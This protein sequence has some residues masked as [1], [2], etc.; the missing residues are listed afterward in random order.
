MK[1]SAPSL[2]TGVAAMC[3][4]VIAG[5]AIDASQNRNGAPGNFESHEEQFKYGS[6]GIESEEGLPYWIFQ[7]L[8]R[9]FADKL[10]RPGGYDS[11]GFVWEPGHE[12]PI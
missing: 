7:A 4:A 1:L 2:A 9:V 10:P 12:L 5:A 11:F 6:V 3:F 8:P